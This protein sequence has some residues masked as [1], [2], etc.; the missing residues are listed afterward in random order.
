MYEDDGVAL[1]LGGCD[2]RH[3]A[4][5]W[6]RYA[7]RARPGCFQRSMPLPDVMKMGG[8][9]DLASVQ[10]YLAPLDGDKLE[11]AVEAAWA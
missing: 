3:R 7:P 5:F 10:R 2:A 8:W 4:A 1:L 11:T 9:H 6:S